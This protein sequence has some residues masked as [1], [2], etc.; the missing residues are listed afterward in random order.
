MILIGELNPAKYDKQRENNFGLH[1]LQ[2]TFISNRYLHTIPTR[3]NDYTLT[4]IFRPNTIF[5]E[6]NFA[7]A[8]VEGKLS[9]VPCWKPC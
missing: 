7:I 4:I 1:N 2:P 8:P 6:F 3:F 5:K 9:E